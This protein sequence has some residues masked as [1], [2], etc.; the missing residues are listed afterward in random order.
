[1]VLK[2]AA[3]PGVGPL[4]QPGALFQA[5]LALLAL[6]NRLRLLPKGGWQLPFPHG[7]LVVRLGWCLRCGLVGLVLIA[8]GDRG[9]GVPCRGLGTIQTLCSVLRGPPLPDRQ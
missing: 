7:H 4:V 2:W 6:G 3:A 9:C 1:M 8:M 5:G